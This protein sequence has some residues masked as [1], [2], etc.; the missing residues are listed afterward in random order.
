MTQLLPCLSDEVGGCCS[1]FRLRCIR[2]AIDFP[3]GVDAVA[4]RKNSMRMLTGARKINVLELL[5]NLQR[6]K[7]IEYA[8]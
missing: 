1:L 7:K 8:G 5:N 6:L 4:S 2:R 3:T